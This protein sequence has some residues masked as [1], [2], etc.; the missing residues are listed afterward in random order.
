MPGFSLTLLLLPRA[1]ESSPISAEGL[2]ALLDE[3]ASVPGWKRTAGRA[4]IAMPI[5]PMANMTVA[6]TDDGAQMKAGDETAFI[7]A[8]KRACNAVITEEAE[9]TRMDNIA[10][11]GDCGLTLKGGAEGT[12][13]MPQ[14]SPTPEMIEPR[15]P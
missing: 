8:I 10:G 2:L 13:S 14:F 12:S 5:E 9:I 11:D 3:P 4:P 15:I 6:A 7:E 1:S